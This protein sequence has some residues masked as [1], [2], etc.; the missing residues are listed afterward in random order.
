[1]N[2]VLISFII[3]LIA[4]LSTILGALFIYLKPKNI[5]NF[6]GMCLSFSAT[7]MLLISIF[8]LIPDGF[9]YLNNK[10]NLIYAFLIL[11]LMIFV[12]LFINKLINKKIAQKSQNSSNLYR[13]GVLSMIALMIHNLPEGILTFISSTINIKL[14]LKLAL[15]IMLHNIPEGI[16]IAVP[17][18]Y[19]TNSKKRGVVGCLISGLSEP[20]GALLAYICLY[21]YINNILMSYILLFVAGIMIS[22]S[23]NDIFKEIKKYSLKSNIIGVAIGIIIYIVTEVFL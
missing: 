22:I 19:S 14:G 7:I 20:I 3:S 5:N 2:K 17:I 10:Y 23:I 4:G 6:I 11:F 1:M 21:K 12:G 9:F 13:V 8:E 18:Y 16:A 15:A